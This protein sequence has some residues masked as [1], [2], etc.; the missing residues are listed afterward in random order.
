MGSIAHAPLFDHRAGPF[1]LAVAIQQQRDHHLHV[2]WKAHTVAAMQKEDY[3]LL[4]VESFEV[5]L[6][7]V[8]TIEQETV[9]GH[10][11]W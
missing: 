10:R 5:N 2:C 9:V 1:A 8:D 4:R 3:F 7:G 6:A 11:W